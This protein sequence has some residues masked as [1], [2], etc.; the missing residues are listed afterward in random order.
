MPIYLDYINYQ[1][2]DGFNK[3]NSNN[4]SKVNN[5]KIQNPQMN[6]QYQEVKKMQMKVP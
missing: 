1:I 5:N 2:K 6:S 3:N 4:N